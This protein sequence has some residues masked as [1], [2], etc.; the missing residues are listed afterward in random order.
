MLEILRIVEGREREQARYCL[1]M[2]L[3][4]V[5]SAVLF[6]VGVGLR[7]GMGV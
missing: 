4:F 7:I 5:L 1:E 6:V 2:A 3:A